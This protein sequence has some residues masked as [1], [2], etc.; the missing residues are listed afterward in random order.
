MKLLNK[1]LG[2][3]RREIWK[4]FCVK[5]GADY[6]SGDHWFSESI[7]R[8]KHR[9]W[10]IVLD[11]YPIPGGRLP[12]ACTR[13]HALYISKD[14][15]RFSLDQKDIAARLMNFLGATHTKAGPP[16]IDSIEPLFGIPSY[17]DMKEIESNYCG[18]DEKVIMKANDEA[19]LRVLFK[20]LKI[21]ELI[22]S[23]KSL[24]VEAREFNGVG[25]KFSQNVYEL[26]VYVNDLVRD[27]GELE[28]LYNIV[29]KILDALC[30]IESA[31]Q[32]PPNVCL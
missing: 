8:A 14:G 25:T 13:M 17:I 28:T 12:A 5:I 9:N 18:F 23:Q 29:L 10:T 22:Q 4:Q 21:R 11:T 24:S 20:D 2:Q 7:I 16:Q 6:E 27:L 3:S 32:N 30:D 19:K 26:R 31:D 1:I 15:F